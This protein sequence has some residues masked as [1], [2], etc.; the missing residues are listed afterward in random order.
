MQCNELSNLLSNYRQH[1][2]EYRRA[3]DRLKEDGEPLI[4]S[5]YF[6]L[7]ESAHRAMNVCKESQRRLERH[8]MDHRCSFDSDQLTS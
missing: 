7:W 4:Q 6:L 2:E 5:E 1:A 8:V 3:V